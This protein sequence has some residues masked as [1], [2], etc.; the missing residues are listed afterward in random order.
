M[1]HQVHAS[2]LPVTDCGGRW[3]RETSRI[4]HFLDTRLIVG[5][6]VDLVLVSA[7][8][9]VP[10]SLESLGGFGGLSDPVRV[11]P[12]D[13]THLGVWEVTLCLGVLTFRSS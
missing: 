12:P 5:G 6:E 7:P 4:S 9:Y 2:Y 11:I 13:V 3:S 1:V 8:F 10:G